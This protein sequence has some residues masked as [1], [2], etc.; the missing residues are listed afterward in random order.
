MISVHGLSPEEMKGIRIACA[1][2]FSPDFAKNDE[3]INHLTMAPI[4]EAINEKGRRYNPDLHRDEASEMIEKRR[5][6]FLRLQESYTL[7]RKYFQEVTSPSVRKTNPNPTLIAI[8]GAK[9]GIGKSLLAANLGVFF[10]QRGKETV[11]IDLDLG[12]SNLH[13]YLGET[14][15]PRNLQDFLTHRV[16]RL[17]DA[18]VPTKY[19]PK[20][21]G[22]DSSRLGAANI[23][24]AQK[25]KLLKAI[26]SIE[27]DCVIIDLGG[28]TSYNNLDFF[29]AAHHGAVL[30]TCDPASYMDAYTFIKVCLYRKLNRLFGP[31]TNP[32]GEKDAD[33]IQ[34]IEESTLSS[35]G[36]AIKSIGQLMEKVV[37]ERPQSL[38]VL[39]QA[40]AQFRPHLVVSMG[41]NEAD[42]APV[43]K[44]V[45][46]VALKMLSIQVDY[47]GVIPYMQEIRR[48]TRELVPA[49]AKFPKGEVAGYLSC[50]VRRLD[51]L[52]G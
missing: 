52:N 21:I 12:G 39:H 50:L 49:V 16:A 34:L 5:E 17:E 20:L 47:L 7:L 1:Y 29:L 9:G 31:E 37:Q 33:L 23:S 14:S 38:P 36:K 35:N 46:E 45:Q 25:V 18:M 10:S 42:I 41:E 24:F 26:K 27:A 6:R 32:N 43:V 4:D 2:L 48:S 13:L 44:R 22:G 28:D 30:T 11:L 19:G 15:L 8:G 51:G 40:L 3:A